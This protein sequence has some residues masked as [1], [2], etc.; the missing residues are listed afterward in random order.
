MAATVPEEWRQLALDSHAISHRMLRVF[1][2]ARAGVGESAVDALFTEWGRRFFA[3]D[4][5]DDR[6]SLSTQ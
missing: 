3:L 5:A 1:E 4:P 2:A 6:L